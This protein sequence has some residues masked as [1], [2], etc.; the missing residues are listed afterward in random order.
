MKRTSVFF[1]SLFFLILIPQFAHAY[2]PGLL[3]GKSGNYVDS[4]G[5]QYNN[6][7]VT[8]TTDGDLSTSLSI[9]PRSHI[10]YTF[11]EPVSFDRYYI[12]GGNSDTYM[13]I[14]Y[15]G[16]D[17][18]D[19]ISKVWGRAPGSIKSLGKVYSNVKSVRLKQNSAVAVNI[20]AFEVYYAEDLEPP[21]VPS[22]LTA[23][24]DDETVI[25]S[26][27]PNNDGDF[28]YYVIYRDGVR[29]GTSQEPNYSISGLVNGQEYIFQ[30]SAVDLSGNESNKSSGIGVV[31]NY[32]PPKAPTGLS[33]IRSQDENIEIKWNENEENYV[34]G[35]VIYITGPGIIQEM[36]TT[37]TRY[38]I[39]GLKNESNYTIQV[40][41]VDTTGRESEKSE[42]V[43][44]TVI[45]TVPP[46]A[47]I[48]TGT[49][50]NE[51]A[52]LD[53]SLPPEDDVFE[54]A[55][56]RD[57]ER[58][59]TTRERKYT[60][61]GLTNDQEYVFQV[62]AIDK[63]G[64]ESR[65]S[66]EL[67]ITPRE[68]TTPPVVPSGLTAKAGDGS[69]SLSWK[70]NTEDDDFLGFYIYIDGKRWNDR[71]LPQNGQVISGLKNGQEYRF[72]V[73]AVDISGNES[74]RSQEVTATPKSMPAPG[75][76]I[77][78]D[79]IHWGLTPAD[80]ISNGGTIVL[81]LS[82]F[83]LLG[84]AVMYVPSLIRLIRE[85]IRG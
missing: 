41:A 9:F 44:V 22:G 79:A 14:S 62:A 25:L 80:I 3:Y 4:R 50:G 68:D 16:S 65:K 5:G 57:G 36:Y 20:N 28:S 48:L 85:A 34:A 7:K 37:N 81:S 69:V 13:Y 71:P 12:I 19:S 31:P 49:H 60:V 39:T 64:N 15:F 51:M 52:L 33:V 11:D 10:T 53:W 78:P 42:P 72:S 84:I 58:I 29:I 54:Y 70:A 23:Q 18:T 77:N 17:R 35:Y 67:R 46:S 83:V 76:G 2:D 21:A 38:S 73:S 24:T 61:E 26:W 47:P 74:E 30:V 45:D 82:L 75:T 59:G 1:L 32:P 6:P 43:S 8:V 40:S 27:K 56:Y 66:N 63:S 55:L